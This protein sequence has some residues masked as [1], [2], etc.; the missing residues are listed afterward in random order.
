VLLFACIVVLVVRPVFV[1]ACL[2]WSLKHKFVEHELQQQMVWPFPRSAFCGAAVF[3][4]WVVTSWFGC[5]LAVSHLPP[6]TCSA[7]AELLLQP[8]QEV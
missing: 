1:T 3:F 8:L 5:E 2:E 7:A 4:M 6:L